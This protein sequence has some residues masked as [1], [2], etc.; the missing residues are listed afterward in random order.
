MGAKEGYKVVV[1]ITQYPESRRNPE[2]RIIEI[3][4]H[5]DDVG[6]DILSIIKKMIYLKNSLQK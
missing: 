3:L 1:E 6:T 4:G 2:G 5:I